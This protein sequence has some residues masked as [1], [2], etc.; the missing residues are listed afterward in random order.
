HDVVVFGRPFPAAHG[1]GAARTQER[2]LDAFGWK[3]VVAFDHDGLVAVRDHAI[4]PDGFHRCPYSAVGQRHSYSCV[5]AS[6][7]KPRGITA[8]SIASM[9]SC[10]ASAKR[11]AGIAPERIS[12]TSF[13]RM[14][15]RIG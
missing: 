15:R 9:A 8:H 7:F 13:R 5:T 6:R 3:I 12:E 4:V 14:P 1:R 10:K 2:A 11:A